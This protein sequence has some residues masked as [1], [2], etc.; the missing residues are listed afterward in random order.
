MGKDLGEALVST[1][2]QDS[3]RSNSRIIEQWLKFLSSHS[4]KRNMSYN[5]TP[6]I[7]H[8]LR[9]WN[10]LCSRNVRNKRNAE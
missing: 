6:I 7:L 1:N 4:T 10:L 8:R 3:Q 2:F 9:I 5:P